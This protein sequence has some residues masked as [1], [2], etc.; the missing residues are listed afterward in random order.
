MQLNLRHIRYFLVVAEELHF[1]RAAARLNLAQPALSQRIQALELELKVVLFDR[2]KRKVELTPAGQAFLA[3]SRQ[4]LADFDDAVLITQRT[5]RDD[6]GQLS[7]GTIPNGMGGL[8]FREILPQFKERFPRVK[9]IVQ[10]L[11]TTSQ[12]ASLHKGQLDVALLRMPV[13]DPLLSFRA[14]SRDLLAVALPVDHPKARAKILSLASVAQEPQIMFPRHLAPD[15]Y[16]F[17]IGLLQATGASFTVAHEADHL[18]THLGL[19][20]GGFGVALMPSKR[21]IQYHGVVYRA[22]SAPRPCIETAFAFLRGRETK[23]IKAF[24]EIA[25]AVVQ[26]SGNP[27]D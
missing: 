12:I 21:G 2:S 17:L 8:L 15:Y 16:D 14:G 23:L 1:G 7:V 18:E 19:V 5:H 11:S 9:V 4:I 27:N 26:K 10:S 3:R 6:T 25:T 22:L 24:I 20:A 13:A